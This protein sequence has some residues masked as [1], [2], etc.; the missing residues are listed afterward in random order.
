MANLQVKNVP[1]DVYR[2]IQRHA[3]RQGRTIRD[4]VLGAVLRDIGRAEFNERLAKREP[5]NLGRSAGR[6]IEEI[7]AEREAELE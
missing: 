2:K 4:V 1:A 5:V 3:K 6:M 7:R